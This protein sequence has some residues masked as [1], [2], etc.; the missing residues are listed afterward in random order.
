[1]MSGRTSVT[2]DVAA[3]AAQSWYSEIDNYDFDTG[4]ASNGKTIG[5][6]TQVKQIN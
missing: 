1:M 2:D 4:N 3:N 5:H 6:F